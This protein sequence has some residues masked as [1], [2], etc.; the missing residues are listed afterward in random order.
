VFHRGGLGF[1]GFGGCELEGVDETTVDVE[2]RFCSGMRGRVEGRF[3]RDGSRMSSEKSDIGS[4]V[5]G[6][7]KSSVSENGDQPCTQRTGA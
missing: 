3:V 6:L 5:G 1:S 2:E 7:Q 4:L